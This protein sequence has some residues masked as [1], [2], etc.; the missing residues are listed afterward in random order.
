MN[1]E[2][3]LAKFTAWRKDWCL[4]ARQMLQVNL[5]PD[6]EEILRS[7]QFN[8]MT[9]V[10]SGT[11]RGKDFV[12]AVAAVCFLYLTPKWNS[13]GELVENTKV[14]MTAPSDRQVQNIMVPEVRRI[15]EKAK[16]LP[17]RLTGYDIRTDDAEWFLTGFK[18][19]EYKPEVWTGFH[20]V[21]TMFIV[22]EASGLSDMVFNSIE[23]N[24]QGNS[25][26]LIVFNPN[27]ATGY[28]A[29]SQKSN[30]WHKFRLDS[31]T[32]PN[33]LQK[34][35]IIPGQ[36]D[37]EW[38]KDKVETWC[39]VIPEAE[40]SESEGDFPWEGFYY[41]PNDLFRVK[42]RGMFPKVSEDVLVPQYW[43]DLAKDRWSKATKEQIE[44]IKLSNQPRIGNDVA[45]MGRDSSSFCNRF[46]PYVE[47]IKLIQ[48]GG[49][50]NHMEIAG[51]AHM[52]VKKNFDNSLGRFPQ[53]FIDTVGEGAGV[54]S[55]VLEL[56]ADENNKQ[57]NRTPVHSVKGGESA[58]TGSGQPLKDV[59][60]QYTFKNMRAYLYW[61]VR[62]WLNPDNLTGA[63]LPPD[64][65]Y[66]G[67][68]ETKWRMRSDGS[69][70]LESKEELK[71]RIKKSPDEE[72]SLAMTFY[73]VSDIAP[74]TNSNKRSAVKGFF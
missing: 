49:V 33:V 74:K 69:I 36:V 29:S 17:G 15:F 13:K 1:R 45:G 52:E 48:S 11:A 34:E 40:V 60:G 59:T 20:A 25:R 30:R 73:P 14:A 61:C 3:I 58:K 41:R 26:M 35:I 21:N 23:G 51:L 24:L 32:A 47:K 54:Y 62:D 37:Y 6:Q 53:L 22:T 7:V 8:K 63:M 55:R 67:L 38:V 64:H 46:G 2:Q 66:L 72:D 16:F 68:S 10:S 42:V 18:A 5:D 71:S 27:V 65:E 9:S 12:S 43:I 19:D 4:F 50:A 39:Q 56:K 44:A 28:A 31:L 57:L 70:E